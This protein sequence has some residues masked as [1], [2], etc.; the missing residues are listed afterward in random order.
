MVSGADGLGDE[1]VGAEGLGAD[2]FAADVVDSLDDDLMNGA[3]R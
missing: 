1:V 3:E 2:V